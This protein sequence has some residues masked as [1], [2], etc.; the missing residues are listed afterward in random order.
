[1]TDIMKVGDTIN[2]KEVM[3][4]LEIAELTGKRHADVMRDIRNIME[5]LDNEDNAIL[6]YPLIYLN[7]TKNSLCIFLAKKGVCV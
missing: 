4:S 3:S 6:R 2:A 5:Q 7:K 1:M